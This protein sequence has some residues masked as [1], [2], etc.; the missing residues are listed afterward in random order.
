MKD[1]ST[2][3]QSCPRNGN[4]YFGLNTKQQIFPANHSSVSTLSLRRNQRVTKIIDTDSS[5]FRHILRAREKLPTLIRERGSVLTPRVK[6]FHLRSPP[7]H[8]AS[9]T[10]RLKQKKYTEVHSASI[11]TPG[12]KMKAICHSTHR[13]YTGTHEEYILI[14]RGG[15]MGRRIPALNLHRQTL[16]PFALQCKIFPLA[17]T[18]YTAGKVRMNRSATSH[19]SHSRQFVQNLEPALFREQRRAHKLRRKRVAKPILPGNCQRS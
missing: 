17:I 4:N 1:E 11:F 6:D 5:A 2:L 12:H 8:E 18:P 3:R 7:S 15:H 10:L 16:R 19:A 9:A 14:R 13:R